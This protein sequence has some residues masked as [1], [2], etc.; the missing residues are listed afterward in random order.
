MATK[1]EGALRNPEDH[2]RWG[3]VVLLFGWLCVL[4]LGAALA[5]RDATEWY[6]PLVVIAVVLF[7]AAK[8]GADALRRWANAPLLPVAT[9]AGVVLVG[10]ALCAVAWDALGSQIAELRDARPMAANL[11]TDHVSATEAV[12]YASGV[13]L[14]PMIGAAA[15]MLLARRLSR[16][17]LS[18]WLA[19]AGLAATGLCALLVVLGGIR[20]LARPSVDME[21]RRLKEATE[22]LPPPGVPRDIDVRDSRGR[23]LQPKTILEPGPSGVRRTAFGDLTVLQDCEPAG[24]R[25]GIVDNVYPGAAPDA[26]R[27]SPAVA[28]PAP[29]QR[30]DESLLL[31]RD[32]ETGT[33]YLRPKHG[34]VR[35]E[36]HR[37]EGKWAPAGFAAR[38][39]A[40]RSA[41][42]RSWF[43]AAL[44][45]LAVVAAL[46]LRGRAA[47]RR[48]AALETAGAGVLG[49]DGWIQLDGGATGRL[50]GQARLP[51]GPVVVLGSRASDSAYRDRLFP[52]RDVLP[53]T[54]AEHREAAL[55]GR[56]RADAAILAAA[57]LSAA[58]LAAAIPV[59][60]VLPFGGAAREPLAVQSALPPAPP[61]PTEDRLPPPA[62]DQTWRFR[63]VD[64]VDVNHDGVEDAI[65]DCD[66][67]HAS[68]SGALTEHLPCAID[69][70]TMRRLW[71]GLSS[72]MGGEG[73]LARAGDRVLV[74]APGD[75]LR[76]LDLATGRSVHLFA[77]PLRGGEACVPD[78]DRASV[79]LG[80]RGTIGV[81]LDLAS[82]V[83]LPAPRP[84]SCASRW[85]FPCERGFEGL[86]GSSPTVAETATLDQAGLTPV[87]VFR[88][89][90]A[91]LVVANQRLA[92]AAPPSSKPVVAALGERSSAL[93]WTVPASTDDAP[94]QANG[95]AT[96]SGGVLF[97]GY[98]TPQGHLQAADARTGRRIWDFATQNVYQRAPWSFLVSKGRVYVG[99]GAGLAVLDQ[100]TGALLGTMD[101]T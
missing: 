65:G 12:V 79:W 17:T 56:I 23:P 55:L 24:C 45:G 13:L 87:A 77:K 81:E 70:A 73:V 29:F 21:L 78:L 35:A 86:C 66:L 82:G 80:V 11:G 15:G 5:A 40:R 91:V 68:P 43:L 10:V 98:G 53:G 31:T 62:P 84:A 41:P 101:G 25:I 20:A 14:V 89:D 71:R 51:P 46:Q 54:L 96:V 49:E 6:A 37:V 64:V 76:A 92:G 58:P 88:T 52:A 7:L 48:E 97:F 30:W 93:L 61:V 39:I 2:A 59:G 42:P 19:K 33:L 3:C 26:P 72:G 100:T 99:S 67:P 8:G 95:A 94:G 74:R 83:A 69:G 38:D 32:R 90:S 1:P 50:D 60:L 34:K 36:L 16:P 4:G 27:S 18:V 47:R 28:E 22:T 9:S 85:V 63:A 75:R 57:F 44:L